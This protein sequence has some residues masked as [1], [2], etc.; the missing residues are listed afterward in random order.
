MSNNSRI[1]IFIKNIIVPFVLLLY[2]LR[3]VNQGVDLTDIGYNLYNYRVFEGS[4]A[5]WFNV[6]TYLSNVTGMLIQKL[7]YADSL[8]GF[9]IYSSLIVSAIS[10]VIYFSIRK[11]I[12]FWIVL[13]GEIVAISLCWCPTVILYNYLTYL[14][15]T[16]GAIALYYA[17]IK[18][19]KVLF[20]VAGVLLGINVMV[21]VP[22]VVES[23]LILSVWY[24]AIL[25]NKKTRQVVIE[26]LLCLSGF[27]IG[28]IVG[29]IPLLFQYGFDGFVNMVNSIGQVGNGAKDYSMFSMITKPIIAYIEQFKWIVCIMIPAIAACSLQKISPKLKYLWVFIEAVMVVLIFKGFHGRGVYSLD[30]SSYGPIFNPT[31]IVLAISIGVYIACM[32]SKKVDES[33]KLALFIVLLIIL[34]TPIGTNNYNYAIINNLFLVMPVTLFILYKFI[35]NK[36]NLVLIK[37][38][39][40]ATVFAMSVLAITFGLKFTFLGNNIG[41]TRDGMVENI[42]CLEGM[43][44]DKLRVS[45]IEEVYAYLIDNELDGMELITYGNIPAIHYYVDME[46]YFRTSWIDLNSYLVDSFDE[47][48]KK[49][50]SM[51]KD[52]RPVIILSRNVFDGIGTESYTGDYK[53][54]KIIDIIEN[55]DYIV[56]LQNEQF[57]IFY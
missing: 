22:N 29:M 46:A 13:F 3:M 56:K 10:L 32:F 14:F 8:L 31:L 47:D 41:T 25:K 20:I 2:P 48:Y 44:T 40:A 11:I 15:F 5:V 45:N 49:V 17:L 16:L 6:A 35:I 19:K 7:P 38:P 4:K 24:Y 43:M 55:D 26:T 51:T 9:N 12:P 54:D 42:P 34:I 23:L 52:T 33:Q 57:V 30:F 39:I 18:E 21:R 50:E 1:V 53:L 36:N 37:I 27:I 28:I